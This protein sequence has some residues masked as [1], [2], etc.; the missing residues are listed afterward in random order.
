MHRGLVVVMLNLGREAVKLE[1]PRRLPLLMSS[2]D[3]IEADG[4]QVL[5]P[6][7]GLAILSGESGASGASGA[8]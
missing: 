1:N 3:G 7:E 6:P 8:R 4:E 5:L 2:R